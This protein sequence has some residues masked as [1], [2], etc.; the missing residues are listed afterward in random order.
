MLLNVAFERLVNE[1]LIVPAASTSKRL[2]AMFG[3]V[4]A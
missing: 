2:R 1:T 3:V 4:A